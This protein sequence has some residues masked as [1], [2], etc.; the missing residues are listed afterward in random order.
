MLVGID[1]AAERA[2]IRL[3]Q[4]AHP[5]GGRPE[6]VLCCTWS[7]FTLKLSLNLAGKAFNGGFE[8][9]TSV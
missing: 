1:N 2:L 7:N 6:P 4:A 5:P 9:L 3:W 8:L